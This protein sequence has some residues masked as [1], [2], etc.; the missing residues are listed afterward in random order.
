MKQK[1]TLKIIHCRFTNFIQVYKITVICILFQL[2]AYVAI[3]QNSNSTTYIPSVYAL[4]E[5]DTTQEQK[6]I[7][8]S[9]KLLKDSL[10][11]SAYNSPHLTWYYYDGDFSRL[12]P[13]TYN[14]GVVTNLNDTTN[15]T[16]KP[17]NYYFEVRRTLLS[18]DEYEVSITLCS[19]KKN[20]YHSFTPIRVYIFYY[21][22]NC[23][24][25]LW[26]YNRTDKIEY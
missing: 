12:P 13:F 17:H 20:K 14:G 2:I 3:G 1:D 22:Y 7:L 18:H 11:N 15:F 26:K 4:S 25:Q 23:A 6:L 5:A 9:F 16:N 19:S 10:R 21:E 24:E 8:E